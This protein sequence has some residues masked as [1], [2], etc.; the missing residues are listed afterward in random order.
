MIS[1]KCCTVSRS[2]SNYYQLRY[3]ISQLILFTF[4]YT[5]SLNCAAKTTSNVQC[6]RQQMAKH[7]S[8]VYR[9]YTQMQA[10]KKQ[11][12]SLEHC[13]IN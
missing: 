2:N 7:I 8:K 9:T 3:L 4:S 11:Q 13:N 12:Q 10:A 5:S 6:T 1:T